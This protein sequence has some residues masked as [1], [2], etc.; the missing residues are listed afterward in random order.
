MN[1]VNMVR[2]IAML[3]AVRSH[4]L[5][6]LARCVAALERLEQ[7]DRRRRRRRRPNPKPPE[8]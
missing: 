7:P 2:R 3:P 1:I 8:G 4:T 5:P 6:A